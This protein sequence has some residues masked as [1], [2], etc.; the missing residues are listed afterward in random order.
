MAAQMAPAPSSMKQTESRH[1]SVPK[2]VRSIASP[3]MQHRT[4]NK[5]MSPFSPR[6]VMPPP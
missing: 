1:Q 4:M 2:E 6:T 3:K 5:A